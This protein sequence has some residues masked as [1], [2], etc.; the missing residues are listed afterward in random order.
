MADFEFTY[1]GTVQ[2]LQ[3]LRELGATRAS[4][5]PDGELKRVD[6]VTPLLVAQPEAGD[7]DPAP[8]PADFQTPKAF[9]ELMKPGAL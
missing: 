3:Q 4:F 2:L 7:T 5:Y 8:A 9:R 1:G 6:F